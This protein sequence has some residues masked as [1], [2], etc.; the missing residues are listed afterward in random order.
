MYP[1]QPP[2]PPQPPRQPPYTQPIYPQQAPPPHP[3][4][5][6][7][8]PAY[9]PQAS[10]PPRQPYAVMPYQQ[11]Y[12]PQGRRPDGAA[13]IAE[14]ALALFGIYGVGWL[15]SGKTT[16]GILLMVGGILWIIL[17]IV[18]SIF[19]GGLGA[20]C[21]LPLHLGAIATSVILLSQQRIMP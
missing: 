3:C 8:Y 5:Q 12:P 6:P 17:V 14:A 2:Q 1:S 19:T 7:P 20:C 10:Y 13:L 11:P 16:A 4:M 9:P 21:L 15:M 18:G